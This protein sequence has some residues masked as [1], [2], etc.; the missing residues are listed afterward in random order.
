[1]G[2]LKK[3]FFILLVFDISG[4]IAGVISLLP[5]FKQM[6]GYGQLML[7]VFSV[8]FAGLM[9]IQLFEILSKIF[10][11]KSTSPTFSWTSDRKG[12]LT[13]ARLLLL[14]N[15]GA[16]IVNLL[17]AGGEG[18]TPLNQ[19]YLFLQ[20][21]ASVAEILVVIIY[22]RSIKSKLGR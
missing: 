10:M 4:L 14:F 22:L 8:M 19:G 15:F 5:T 13:V 2:L 16:V 7:G 12:Y 11:I 20:V 6:A 3:A 17:S 18:A 9:A 1:M 21:L